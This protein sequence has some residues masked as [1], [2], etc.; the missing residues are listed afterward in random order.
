VEKILDTFNRPAGNITQGIFRGE[1]GVGAITDYNV[2]HAGM[3]AGGAFHVDER[4]W[5]IYDADS[6][7]QRKRIVKL[8]M[9]ESAHVHNKMHIDQGNPATAPNL[10][11]YPYFKYVMTNSFNSCIRN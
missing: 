7:Q 11:D 10:A 2:V 6:V 1:N 8:L 4:E 3:T 5:A 9:H